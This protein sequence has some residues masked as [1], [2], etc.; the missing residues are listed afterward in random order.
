M[1]SYKFALKQAKVRVVYVGAI[2]VLIA[3]H[4]VKLES[5]II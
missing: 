3:V 5:I 2:L 4:V 1:I